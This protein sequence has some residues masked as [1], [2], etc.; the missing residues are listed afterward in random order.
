MELHLA[1]R[2]NCSFPGRDSCERYLDR[3]PLAQAQRDALLA[4][5]AELDVSSPREAM[6]ALHIALAG[7][8]RKADPDN[9]AV[10]SICSRLAIGK[11]GLPSATG[12]GD[13]APAQSCLPTG[14]AVNRSSMAPLRWPPKPSFRLFKSRQPRHGPSCP[15]S[16]K[17]EADPGAT[18]GS[19]QTAANLRRLALLVLVVGQVYFFTSAMAAVLPYHGRRMLE[20]A[21]L[22]VFAILTAW[23]SLGFWTA[24]MGFVVKVTGGDRFA[25][26]ASATADAPIDEHARTAVIMPICNENVARVFAGLRATYESLARTSELRHF[27]FFILSDSSDADNRV[28]EVDAWLALCRAVGGFG[29]VF[30]RWRQHRLKRKSGNVADFCRRWGA[31]YRYMIVLDADSVMSGECLASLVRLMEANPG[32]GI[33]Q[34]APLIAG[35][36]TL[37]ASMQQFANRVYGPLF[38]AGL[39]FWQLGESHY[40]GHNAIL[41]VAP[42][43]R[44]CALGRLSGGGPLS[45][46]ILSH[47]FVEAA[48]MRRAGWTVWIAYDLPGSYEEVPPNLVDELKRDRR[49]CQGNLM[50]VRLFLANGVHPAHRAVFL[51]GVAAYASAPLWF[52]FL[53]LS[54]AQLAEHALATPQ[55]FVQ[56]FQLFP[57]WP[58]WNPQRAIALFSFTAAL[59]FLPKILSVLLVWIQGAKDFGGKL[60][61]VLSMVMESL[62]S[63]LLAPIRMLFHTTFVLAPLLGQGIQWKSPPREDVETGWGEALRRHGRHTLLGL[64]W[65]AGVYWLKPSYLLWLMPVVGAL[66]LSIPVSVL[67]SRVSLGQR[68]RRLRFFLIP[69]ELNQPEELRRTHEHA[70]HAAA[71]PDFIEAVTDPVINA[72]I[73][74]TGVPRFRQSRVAEHRAKLVDKALRGGPDALGTGHKMHLL[75]DPIAFSRLHFEVWVSAEAHPAWRKTLS[76]TT[77]RLSCIDAV[78]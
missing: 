4:Q 46:E 18:R 52:L 58:E 42:F 59:L 16:G 44:H 35:R 72:T 69:E 67:S 70:A 54:T 23:V 21:I 12:A 43:M 17:E 45:G 74:A 10:A 34:S 14:P 77:G 29:Q 73:C 56:P 31:N 3:L 26:S 33:I 39:H 19:W 38:V 76:H 75:N 1:T 64:A 24:I 8:G 36:D 15:L 6:A 61:L 71:P 48:L 47:D 25:I 9:P 55:Y 11:S 65:A 63:A 37:Y 51:T 2:L 5:L 49:W 41:R 53:L 60:R 68:L 7:P 78:S 66:I 28:A 27:D 22:I 57:V 13:A 20:I 40:W 62:F 50:N 32:A 30:Y